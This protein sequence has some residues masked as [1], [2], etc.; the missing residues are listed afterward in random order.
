[1]I[2]RKTYLRPV[3]NIIPVLYYVTI[4]NSQIKYLLI[5][6]P[7]PM[8]YIQNNSVNFVRT[9]RFLKKRGKIVIMRIM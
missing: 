5:L 9:I 2:S 3:Y 6:L 8:E 7:N 1:L 4:K